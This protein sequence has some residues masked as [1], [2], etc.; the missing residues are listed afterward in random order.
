MSAAGRRS[1]RADVEPV[2]WWTGIPFMVAL[3]VGW[4]LLALTVPATTYHFAPTMV[5]ATWPVAQRLRSG[6][7]LRPLRLGITSGGGAVIVLAVTAVL[8][9]MDALSG[10]TVF[11]TEGAL[12]ETVV[13]TGVGVL[14]GLVFGVK[15]GAR[16]VSDVPDGLP[17]RRDN[18]NLE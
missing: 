18:D 17:T 1:D 12:G 9:S 15:P 2:P 10:P 8:E 6:H 4:M 7:R 3:C 13:M 5:A 14:I 11:G 16:T